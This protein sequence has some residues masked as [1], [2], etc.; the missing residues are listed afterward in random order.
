M[1]IPDRGDSSCSFRY[2]FFEAAFMTLALHFISYEQ[3]TVTSVS[4]LW[5]HAGTSW[6]SCTVMLAPLLW[7][8]SAILSPFF[9]S[10]APM[11][12]AAMSSRA[13]AS[14]ALC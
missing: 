8:S 1:K 3:L 2:A 11:L 4:L 6:L 12:P 9:P 13:C 10:T 5:P 7:H 14:D